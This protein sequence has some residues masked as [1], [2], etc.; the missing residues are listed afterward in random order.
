MA[1]ADL[2]PLDFVVLSHHHGDH[3][4]DIAAAELDKRVPIL[5][6]AHARRQAGPA[7][8]PGR[9]GLGHLGIP[10]GHPW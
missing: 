8:V 5:T 9:G 10:D 4:D 7:G 3:F 1:I 2:P 6:T